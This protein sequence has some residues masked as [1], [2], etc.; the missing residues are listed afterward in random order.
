LVKFPS[1]SEFSDLFVPRV[2]PAT[3]EEV[4]DSHAQP[5]KYT[6]FPE[7]FKKLILEKEQAGLVFWLKPDMDYNKVSQW[8]VSVDD[9]VTGEKYKP[10]ILDPEWWETKFSKGNFSF[11]KR[12][13]V[14]NF[15]S[16]DH[17]YSSVM[18]LLYQSNNTLDPMLQWTGI[19][20]QLGDVDISL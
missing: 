12:R 17:D 16:G 2:F 8:L 7:D 15:Q 20:D 1:N 10:L 4:K 5:T 11:Q 19:G 18:E 6:E 9:P 13:I 3:P 14:S